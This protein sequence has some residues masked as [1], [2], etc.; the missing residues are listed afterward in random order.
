MDE[1]WGK[2]MSNLRI[3]AAALA[4]AVLGACDM[5]GLDRMQPEG[6]GTSGKVI[7]AKADE[8]P[9]TEPAGTVA[10]AGLTSSRSLAGLAGRGDSKDPSVVPT[11]SSAALDPQTLIGR[12]AD[13]EACKEDITIRPNGTFVSYTG[14]AGRW[15]VDGDRLSLTGE[16]GTFSVRIQSIE[17]D[18]MTVLNSDGSIGRSRRC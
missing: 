7:S 6:N 5:S 4:L 18:I 8:P 1:I 16:Q 15:S 13:D 9:A 10:D 11:G 14:G 2:V 17:D 3:A 12:W